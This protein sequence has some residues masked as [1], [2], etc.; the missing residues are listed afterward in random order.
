VVALLMR[1]GASEDAAVLYGA[2]ETPRTG[3]PPFGTDAAM[4]RDA[5]ERLREELGEEEF[6]RQVEAG[7]AMTE[8]ASMRFALDA[9]ARA[10]QRLSAV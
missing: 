1:V 3:L 7:R 6:F 2:A 10:A 9:L 8:G 4:M 5:A